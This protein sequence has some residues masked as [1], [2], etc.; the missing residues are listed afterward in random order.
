MGETPFFLHCH[1]DGTV[2]GQMAKE[3]FEAKPDCFHLAFVGN[4]KGNKAN[5]RQA[6]PLAG[7]AASGLS[8]LS[9][10]AGGRARCGPCPSIRVNLPGPCADG[11]QSS[12]LG[13]SVA[14]VAAQCRLVDLEGNFY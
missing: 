9:S 7:N 3:L 5:C 12:G 14:D 6:G 2:W 8:S 11:H 13:R 10:P 1:M 4:K